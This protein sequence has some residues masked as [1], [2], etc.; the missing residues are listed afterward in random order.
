MISPIIYKTA[1]RVLAVATLFGVLGCSL[2]QTAPLN[3]VTPAK[4]VAAVKAKAKP[5]IVKGPVSDC[6][7]SAGSPAESQDWKSGNLVMV[8]LPWRAHAA[9]DR[10]VAITALQVHRSAAPSLVRAL[11]TIW[12]QTGH[13][14]AEIDRLG[15]SAIGGG[16]N[17][18]PVRD[19]VKLSA[20]AYGCA[21]DFDPD[22]NAL[23]DTSPNFA[24]AE[25]RYVIDAFR[26]EGWAWGG[27]WRR[28]D[29]MHFQAGRVAA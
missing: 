26:E 20:H 17:Y 6:R 7:A 27:Q 15:L 11:N 21:V 5:E 4:A 23:G 16:F 9:W 25:N 22:R 28:P 18:R 2:R 12:L 8:N 13:N 19:G 24:L 1:A 14:Q 3:V 29:G 10:K